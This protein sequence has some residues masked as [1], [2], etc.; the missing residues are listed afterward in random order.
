[1][2]PATEIN[3]LSH[4]HPTQ[5]LLPTSRESSCLRSIQPS[6]HYCKKP[7]CP[8]VEC[9]L[10]VYQAILITINCTYKLHDT[11]FIMKSLTFITSSHTDTC[12]WRT[13]KQLEWGMSDITFEMGKPYLLGVSDTTSITRGLGTDTKSVPRLPPVKINPTGGPR[14]VETYA[15]GGESSSDLGC[16]TDSRMPNSINML[17]KFDSGKTPHGL[18]RG[19]LH[20]QVTRQTS[21]CPVESPRRQFP[22]AVLLQSSESE[23]SLTPE[24]NFLVQGI[25]STFNRDRRTD[26][27]SNIT[28]GNSRYLRRGTEGSTDTIGCVDFFFMLYS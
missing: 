19:P 3:L 4:P 6:S 28:N 9:T 11:H 8:S 20:N 22:G 10:A 23:E 26:I 18:N 27:Q 2:D 25:T 21:Q 5:W 12:I 16:I 17:A 14:S 24:I 1:M 15:C 13:R 7:F